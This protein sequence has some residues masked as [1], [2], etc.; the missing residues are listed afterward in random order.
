MAESSTTTQKITL[1]AYS[2]FADTPV[3][4]VDNELVFGLLK[5]S[6][7]AD[8]SDQTYIVTQAGER[9]LDAISALFYGTPHLWWVVALVNKINDPLLGVTFGTELRVPTKQ[10]LSDAGILSF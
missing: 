10:R 8:P 6:I 1:P 9:R 4:S 3:Y 7:I 2:M 5:D